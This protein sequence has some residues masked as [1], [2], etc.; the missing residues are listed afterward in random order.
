MKKKIGEGDGI[1]VRA[2][3]YGYE[4]TAG[5]MYQEI[6][7]WYSKRENEWPIV[8]KFLNDA[9]DNFTRGL[10]RET[11]FLLLEQ[12]G[13]Q[14]AD[15]CRYTLSYHAYMQYFEYEQLQQT[16]KDSKRAFQ[17]ALFSLIVTITSF[18]VSIYFSN[19]QIN[20]P[21]KLDYWQYQQI[22]NKLK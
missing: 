8:K 5:F 18:F 19:K 1:H 9:F 11:P 20:S 21:T 13:N 4:N 2:V 10:N 16:K 6:E 14:N 15:N 12:L 22:I 17:L 7:K 3:R